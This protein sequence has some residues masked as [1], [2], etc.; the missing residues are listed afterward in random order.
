MAEWPL[1]KYAP[2]Y[3][4]RVLCFQMPLQFIFLQRFV[5]WHVIRQCTMPL[6]STM[7]FDGSES[8]VQ[9]FLLENL[10]ILKRNYSITLI[11]NTNTCNLMCSFRKLFQTT[12][13]GLENS[14]SSTIRVPILVYS[15]AKPSILG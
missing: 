4:L 3:M 11:F 1:S 8:Q 15:N 7:I 5:G 13:P 12:P 2:V 6:F 10:L 9:K 14:Y